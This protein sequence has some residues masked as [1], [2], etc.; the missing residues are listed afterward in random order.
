MLG[1]WEGTSKGEPGAGT[2]R[3]TYSFVLKGRYIHE[4]NVPTYPPQEAN[5]SGEVH[6]HWSFISYD[7][8]RSTL[9]LRQ[10]HQ[11]GFINQFAMSKTASDANKLVFDSEQFE[12]L[13]KQWK[14]RET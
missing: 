9:V 12:N 13:D 14:A 6:E 10:F 7:R 2:V 5:R 8:P 1:E 4:Q 11:E 3:R